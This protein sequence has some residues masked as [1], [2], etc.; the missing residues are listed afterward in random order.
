MRE[1]WYR[2]RQGPAYV[3]LTSKHL[4]FSLRTLGSQEHSDVGIIFKMEITGECLG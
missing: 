3:D 2:L 1:T 4:V